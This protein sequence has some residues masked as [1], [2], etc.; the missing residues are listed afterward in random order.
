MQGYKGV[1]DENGIMRAVRNYPTLESLE[2]DRP[3]TSSLPQV[4]QMFIVT[5]SSMWEDDRFIFGMTTKNIDWLIKEYSALGDVR[6]ILLAI[7]PI[8]LTNLMF[9]LR[10]YRIPYGG[11]NQGL[12]DH[13]VLP[14]RNMSKTLAVDVPGFPNVKPILELVDDNAGNALRMFLRL[15]RGSKIGTRIYTQLHRHLRLLDNFMSY[16]TYDRCMRAMG[17]QLNEQG[18]YE[19][20]TV[21][22]T[23]RIEF[24]EAPEVRPFVKGSILDDG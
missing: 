13:A 1:R 17:Y 2:V 7:V 5:N 10:Q 12:T 22:G 18:S 21:M 15:Y 11:R 8:N 6:V 24:S 9:R 16:E 4:Q 3:N 19:M 14:L 20:P 23:R